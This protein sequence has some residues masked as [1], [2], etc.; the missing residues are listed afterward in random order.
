MRL[1]DEIYSQM[2]SGG[3]PIPGVKLATLY[4]NS[5]NRPVTLFDIDLSAIQWPTNG[6][7]YSTKPVRLCNGAVLRDNITVATPATIYTKGDFNRGTT[8][9]GHKSAALVTL[10]R[11]Y[12][13][14]D[15]WDD[16]APQ[17][18]WNNAGIPNAPIVIQTAFDNRDNPLKQENFPPHAGMDSAVDKDGDSHLVINAALVDGV[19]S[20][21]ELN[22]AAAPNA[23]VNPNYGDYVHAIYLSAAPGPYVTPWQASVNCAANSD[24]LLEEFQ[25]LHVATGYPNNGDSLLKGHSNPDKWDLL[26]PYVKLDRKGS[27]MHLQAAVMGPYTT[28][29]QTWDLAPKVS[30]WLVRSYY[31]PWIRTY[32]A[33]PRFSYPQTL[34]KFT[35]NISTKTLWSASE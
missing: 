23:F 19:P 2:Q 31:T 4:N 15:H 14:S 35:P 1:T 28:S 12:H 17:N 13:L 20:V 22:W 11:I 26:E 30:P 9:D 33:E 10:D 7:I 34:P 16:K 29:P 18:S 3:T 24:C 25:Q 5:E 8:A 27:V 6:L 21:N 32:A